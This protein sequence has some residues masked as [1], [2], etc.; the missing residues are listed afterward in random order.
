MLP[1]FIP[2][3][4]ALVD[5]IVIPDELTPWLRHL[6][7]SD[8]PQIV[9]CALACYEA[10]AGRGGILSDDDAELPAGARDRF[11]EHI[12]ASLDHPDKDV[13]TAAWDAL[14]RIQAILPEAE[15][16]RVIE[17]AGRQLASPRPDIAAAALQFYGSLSPAHYFR[18]N[19]FEHAADG[20]P[21]RILDAI[22][23]SLKDQR[24]AVRLAGWRA[25]ASW[26]TSLTPPQH[27]QI[28]EHI[29]EI[30]ETDRTIPGR[31]L[32]EVTKHL[33][34]RLPADLKAELQPCAQED[35]ERAGEPRQPPRHATAGRRRQ[36]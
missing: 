12:L 33:R 26:S 19:S 15:Q 11:V 20:P 5:R 18:P 4:T 6:F 1:R 34:G 7:H 8:S 30:W 16:A 32:Y 2:G 22:L 9:A 23:G 10:L 29:V 14:G 3:R 31:E 35:R 27:P 21:E 13:W 17:A 24:P 28:L 25:L 36:P